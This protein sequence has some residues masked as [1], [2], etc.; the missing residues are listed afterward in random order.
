[1]GYA[2][3]MDYFPDGSY[4][5]EDIGRKPVSRI[6][7]DKREGLQKDE[8]YDHIFDRQTNRRNY[9]G[10]PVSGAEVD[11]LRKSVSSEDS[12]ELTALPAKIRQP[13]P[14][15]S[16]V[17][18]ELGLCTSLFLQVWKKKGLVFCVP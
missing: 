2:P 3:S 14:V 1:M 15:S 5:L 18:L 11:A 17:L 13:R 10:P 6:T 12:V 16:T 7:L 4:G 8:L 9:E